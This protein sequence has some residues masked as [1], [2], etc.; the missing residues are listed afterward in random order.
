[1]K[2]AGFILIN[3][4]VIFYFCMMI[5]EFVLYLKKSYLKV[6][7]ISLLNSG[8]SLIVLVFSS[9]SLILI[10]GNYEN[11][12]NKPWFLILLIIPGLLRILPMLLVV[13][14]RNCGILDDVQ[15]AKYLDGK[16]KNSFC[17]SSIALLGCDFIIIFEI[18]LAY[19]AMIV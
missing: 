4:V 10:N 6:I 13:S 11:G 7:K 18:F 1:M 16:N 19:R 2:P 12:F 17:N 15:V 9:I 3:V 14:K 5:Y 8:L